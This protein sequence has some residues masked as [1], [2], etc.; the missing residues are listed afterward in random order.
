MLEMAQNFIE[1]RD[2]ILTYMEGSPLALIITAVISILWGILT[3]FLGYRVFRVLLA[4]LGTAS[5]AMI[6]AAGSHWE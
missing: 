1:I 6:G 5:G 4:L 3:G 2:Y